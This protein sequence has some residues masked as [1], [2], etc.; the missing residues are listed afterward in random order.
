MQTP[1]TASSPANPGK[2]SFLTILPAEM[3]NLIYELLF[4]KDEPVLL[5]NSKAFHPKEPTQLEW[6]HAED[7]SRHKKDYFESYERDAG[8]DEEFSHNFCNGINLL[9]TC[10]Q[11]HDEAS[12]VLYAQNTFI[13]S[14]VLDRHDFTDKYGPLEYNNSEYFP[15]MYAAR[16]LSSLGSQVGLLQKVII[17]IDAMCPLHCACSMKE[18]NILPLMRF[19][20]SN[21]IGKNVVTFGQTG[22]ILDHTRF[23]PPDLP[24]EEICPVH[25]ANTLN[26]L[27]AVFVDKDTLRLRRFHTFNRLLQSIE[28][29]NASGEGYVT[30]KSPY[31][32]PYTLGQHFT[33]SPQGRHVEWAPRKRPKFTNLPPEIVSRIYEFACY[34]PD[35]I[36]FDLDTYTAHGLNI[37]LF[38]WT[39]SVRSNTDLASNVAHVNHVTIRATSNTVITNFNDFGHLPSLLYKPWAGHRPGLFEYMIIQASTDCKP[40]TVS[41]EINA[42]HAAT[43]SE[44][45]IN[46]D[47]LMILIQ[48]YEC[49][50]NATLKVTLTC[51]SGWKGETSISIAKLQRQLFLLLSDMISEMRKTPLTTETIPAFR[52]SPREIWI[53]GHGKPV[54][55]SYPDTGISCAFRHDHLTQTELEVLGLHRS[56]ALIR[57]DSQLR[58]PSSLRIT[59]NALRM[60]HWPEWKERSANLDGMILPEEHDAS[61]EIRLVWR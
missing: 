7:Y 39:R 5:H 37:G 28:I 6:P 57:T 10:H 2:A 51:P 8:L 12:G 19:I 24:E 26:N 43:L 15:P 23:Q 3:R 61:E 54:N 45:R 16:W 58:N 29:P 49:H 55:V 60:I 33:V 21:P 27:L 31:H 52:L 30:F 35:G 41:L 25:R 11:L 14:R 18:Y 4:K 44:V 1:R 36:T 32:P 56:I 20:W 46:I 17:D 34:N 42:P 9:L 47:K 13:I 40:L 38:H 22:R 50:P 59:W 48:E 53:D